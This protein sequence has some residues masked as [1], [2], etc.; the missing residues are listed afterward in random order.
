ME[1]T[2]H[3]L[4]LGEL[5]VPEDEPSF[6]WMLARS[7][8]MAR[9]KLGPHSDTCSHRASLVSRLKEL[10]QAERD[11]IDVETWGYGRKL[12]AG[13][14]SPGLDDGAHAAVEL[15][16]DPAPLTAM[17]SD[18]QSFARGRPVE[19]LRDVAVADTA[20]RTLDA[21]CDSAIN[22][23]RRPTLTEVWDRRARD[24]TGTTFISSSRGSYQDEDP[25]HLFTEETGTVR[26][27]GRRG[28]AGH[29][30]GGGG[31]RGGGKNVSTAVR[32]AMADLKLDGAHFQTL[33]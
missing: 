27:A 8:G 4:Q 29:G 24:K 10:A 5:R 33:I 15:M 12:A 13:S 30:E 20:G 19:T 18:L 23:S 2:R 21:A 11:C 7:S 22:A 9:S 16:E 3:V 31:S 14:H 1:L 32:E 6:Q 25:W 26:S 17:L 28:S